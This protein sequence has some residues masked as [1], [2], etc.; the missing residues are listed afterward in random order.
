LAFEPAMRR[1]K[2]VGRERG[3]KKSSGFQEGTSSV[4]G[5][6][7]A[8]AALIAAARPDELAAESEPVVI[9][10]QRR[11][12]GCLT[13][14][15]LKGLRGKADVDHDKKISFKELRDFLQTP[16]LASRGMQHPQVEVDDALLS[17]GIFETRDIELEPQD[18]ASKL[19]T[20]VPLSV[21]IALESDLSKTT[22]DFNL[23]GAQQLRKEIKSLLLAT[24]NT[25]R[26]VSADRTFEAIVICSAQ[27]HSTGTEYGIG[28][29]DGSA[30][31]QVHK[32][33]RHI[34]DLLSLVR[35]ELHRLYTVRNLSRLQQPLSSPYR[36]TLEMD[37]GGY[38][39]RLG[40]TV[41]FI[42][43]ANREGYLTILNINC[44]GETKLLF[45]NE[46][47]GGTAKWMVKGYGHPVKIPDP[48]MDFEFAVEE[49]VGEELIIAFLTPE[50]MDLTAIGLDPN[51]LFTS[52]S[53]NVNI[54]ASIRQ[55]LMR[56]VKPRKKKGSTIA[57]PITTES[58][59]L[60]LKSKN[61]AVARLHF[62]TSD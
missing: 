59:S 40:E 4:R 36:V 13:L 14:K 6:G 55:G 32:T 49:P 10:G 31:L 20:F 41:S 1:I 37:G 62:V 27:K 44:E 19:N 34:P 2:G 56:S 8:G 23:T 48:N 15:L 45:P 24:P 42:C 54:A 11:I 7:V 18:Q 3:I 33:S 51:G 46:Y 50:P 61:W 38:G 22:D 21:A 12:H 57:T 52:A 53:R 30:N 29:A 60:L 28:V 47:M 9:D 26:I 16:L 5:S 39:R 25:L 35:R 43:T 17:R 58:N